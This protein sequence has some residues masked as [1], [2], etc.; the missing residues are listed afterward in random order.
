MVIAYTAL[1]RRTRHAI[2]MTPNNDWKNRTVFLSILK[3]ACAETLKYLIQTDPIARTTNSK[4]GQYKRIPN[5]G[6]QAS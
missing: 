1:V 2:P 5:G 3:K 4:P 6:F